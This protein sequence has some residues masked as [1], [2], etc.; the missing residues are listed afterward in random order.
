VQSNGEF[1]LTPTLSQRDREPLGGTLQFPLPLGEGQGEGND[2]PITLHS[3]RSNNRT[4][5]ELPG[6]IAVIPLTVTILDPSLA[7]RDETKFCTFFDQR[8]YVIGIIDGGAVNKVDAWSNNV[9]VFYICYCTPRPAD[10]PLRARAAVYLRG[11][12]GPRGPS[13][14]ASE[15]KQSHWLRAYK[16]EIAWS[17]RSS[18]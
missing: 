8:S 10:R 11:D 16:T 2:G 6:L 15:A 14:I 1:P 9:K 7:T 5:E 4:T 12:S 3:T 17:L 13:V 18:Q